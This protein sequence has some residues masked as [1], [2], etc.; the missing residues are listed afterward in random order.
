MKGLARSGTRRPRLPHPAA[1]CRAAEG[2]AQKPFL[3]QAPCGRGLRV[4]PGVRAKV[5][6]VG[7]SRSITE[8]DSKASVGLPASRNAHRL[9]P[10]K[11]SIGLACQGKFGDDW[12][13][14]SFAGRGRETWGVDAA[15]M[16]PLLMKAVADVGACGARQHASTPARQLDRQSGHDNASAGCVVRPQGARRGGD[17]CGGGRRAGGCTGK[18]IR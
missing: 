13:N 11:G 17:G 3:H 9:T 6:A 4:A 12:A 5:G 10:T 14:F 1:L 7:L 2:N 16:R 18:S 15:G 8:T